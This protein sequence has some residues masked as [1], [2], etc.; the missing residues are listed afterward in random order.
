MQKGFKDLGDSVEMTVKF[1]QPG[2]VLACPVY[3]KTG[4]I[5]Q[6]AYTPFTTEYISKLQRMGLDTIFY[7]KKSSNMQPIYA[8]D[9]RE[10]LQKNVYK[11][12]RAISLETQKKAMEV[13]EKINRTIKEHQKVSFINDTKDLVDNILHD[14]QGSHHEI[15]NLLDIQTF[16]DHN[17]SHS[18]N[19]GV[20]AM[21][22]AQILGKSKDEVRDIGIASFLHDI[23]KIRLPYDLIHKE[24][25]L[26]NQ[27]L[28]IIRKHPRYGYEIVKESIEL[29]EK[30]KKIILFHHERY[31][32][33]GYPLGL[34]G[35]Q[36]DDDVYIVALAEVYDALTTELSYK[37]AFTMQKA[38]NLI[39]RDSGSV[40]KPEFAHMFT[41]EMTV[42]FKESAYIPDKCDVLL[43]TNEVARVISKD[44]VLT[45][46]PCVEI[47]RNSA[48]QEMK[49]LY[50]DLRLDG[51]R[52][53]VRIMNSYN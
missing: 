42:L 5:V 31:D 19:V 40:F 43:N 18:L 47:I 22:F 39:I 24:D 28:E 36:I 52:H 45:S 34:K 13:T 25:T 33:K 9:L 29:N 46:R 32:G 26:T 15:I 1:I 12:P 41:K 23:G 6:A 11:G 3:S 27:E 2:T 14:I 30:V 16:D 7:S 49:P 44:S 35:D 17:Y 37:K 20:I 38:F 21:L 51:T 50:V 53:I 10:Y 4:D 8:K 48:G